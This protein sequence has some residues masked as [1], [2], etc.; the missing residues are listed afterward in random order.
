MAFSPCQG[1]L[2]ST[3]AITLAISMRDVAMPSTLVQLIN[4]AGV[5]VNLDVPVL[6][7]APCSQVTAFA[8]TCNV[9]HKVQSQFSASIMLTAPS[10]VRWTSP[11][12]CL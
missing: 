2:L 4:P 1:W 10:A 9:R 6:Y 8:A 3:T 12:D 5:S 7:L 11:L